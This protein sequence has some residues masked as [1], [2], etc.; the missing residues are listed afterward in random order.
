MKI[1]KFLKTKYSE[2][3]SQPIVV[4]TASVEEDIDLLA[5]MC[6]FCAPYVKK[7]GVCNKM[8]SYFIPQEEGFL[9]LAEALFMKNGIKMERHRTK[10]LDYMGNE[11]LRVKVDY[12]NSKQIAFINEVRQ[13]YQDLFWESEA[14]EK[15]RLKR[16]YC[17]LQNNT[18][19]RQH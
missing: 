2:Q 7:K 4:N 6:L 9:E 8:Y 11:A 1:L 16:L 19:I 14:Q 3:K 5:T 10:I 12:T 18:N 13:K 17:F 15:E